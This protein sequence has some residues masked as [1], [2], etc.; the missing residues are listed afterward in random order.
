MPFLTGKA[1]SGTGSYLTDEN[2]SPYLLRGDTIWA[3]PIMAGSAGG[4]V[5]WQSDIDAY[6]STRAAQGFNAMYIAAI[7]TSNY[8]VGATNVNGN[9]WDGVSPFVSGSPGSLNSTYWQR[10]DYIMTSAQAQGMTVLFNL[11]PSYVLENAGGPLNGK[12]ASDFTNYGTALGLRYRSAPNLA[13]FIG[14][15]YFDDKQSL[16]GAAVAAI[17][18]TGDTHLFSQEN[19]SESTSRTDMH[20]HAALPTNGANVD[21]NFGYSY[22]TGYL[23]IEDGWLESSPIPVIHGDGIYDTDAAPDLHRNLLWWYLSSGARGVIYGREAIWSWAPTALAKLTT[24]PVDNTLFGAV[25][26]AFSGL[27]N[28]HKLVP[29]T[30]SSLVTAGRGTHA[31]EFTS[32]GGGGQYSSGNVYV[33]ASVTADKTLAV[34]YIPSS[35]TITV[36][37]G[38]MLAGFGAKWMDPFTGATSVATIASTF[39]NA[40]ANSGGTHDWV[41]VLATPPYATWAVP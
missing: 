20:S 3:L 34:I 40:A 29:D 17:K 8:S 21:F 23:A 27:N 39:S 16:Y 31:A 25:M 6:T 15:D 33:S 5:T 11:I 12:V 14:D 26:N 4:A 41:L 19:Y 35:V 10:V 1:G 32:G 37:G 2:G 13:W 36:N 18:A 28:W 38:A 30:T 7:G 22:N 24:N 9:T